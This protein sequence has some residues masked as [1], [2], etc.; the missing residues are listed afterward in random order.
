MNSPHIACT[1]HQFLNA[2]GG[3][4]DFGP[5]SPD[6]NHFIQ[7]LKLRYS[8]FKHGPESPL[9]SISGHLTSAQ[10]CDYREVEPWSK[11][12]SHTAI[13]IFAAHEYRS[14]FQGH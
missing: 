12:D 7:H 3:L 2:S 1:R 11:I 10:H 6:A 9:I 13:G 5:R 4:C 8:P 14:W